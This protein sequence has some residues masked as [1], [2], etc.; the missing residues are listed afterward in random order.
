VVSTEVVFR[1]AGGRLVMRHDEG[2]SADPYVG[3]TL[4]A[5]RRVAEAVG[6]RLGLGSARRGGSRERLAIAAVDGTRS[7]P[8]D[9]AVTLTPM[10]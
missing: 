9:H 8:G 6:V 3:G 2:E 4:L 5:L 10:W 1:G 7:T